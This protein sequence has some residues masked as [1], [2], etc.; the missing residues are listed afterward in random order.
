MNAKVVYRKCS[1]KRTRVMSAHGATK[2]I[3]IEVNEIMII[4]VGYK[5]CGFV[6]HSNSTT[7]VN[8]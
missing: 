7:V 3:G 4:G 6:E 1:I 5:E 8:A 2:Y